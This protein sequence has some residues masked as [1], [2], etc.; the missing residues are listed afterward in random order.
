M[1][2][3]KETIMKRDDIEAHEADELILQAREELEPH[4][5]NGDL[6]ACEMIVMD[7]FGLEPDYLMELID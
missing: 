1:K 4:I 7:Y 3:I 6:E 2:S 5:R